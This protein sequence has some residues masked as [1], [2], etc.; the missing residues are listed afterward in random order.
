MCNR[1]L[2]KCTEKDNLSLTNKFEVSG[3]D[4]SNNY[5][6]FGFID[7]QDS[8]VKLCKLNYVFLVF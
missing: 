5:I 1:T 8:N 3:Y 4:N 2:P 6:Y 7:F